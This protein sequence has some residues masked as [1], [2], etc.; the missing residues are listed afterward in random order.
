MAPEYS[1][2]SI[3]GLEPTEPPVDGLELPVTIANL[4]PELSLEYPGLEFDE[5][6]DATLGSGDILVVGNTR[7]VYNNEVPDG[8]RWCW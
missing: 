5:Y 4:D 3:D 6:T 1:D 7:G 8:W 2:A